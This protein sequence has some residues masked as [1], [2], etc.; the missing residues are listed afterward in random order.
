[1][2]LK[3]RW[4][5][6][7]LIVFL[8]SCSKD[9]ETIYYFYETVCPSCEA[10]QKMERISSRVLEY[11][12][13]ADKIEAKVY[14]IYE[15]EGAMDTFKQLLQER[16]IDGSALVPPILIIKDK[17]YAGFDEVENFLKR[18]ERRRNDD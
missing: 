2:M 3:K 11:G 8:F 14:D 9:V 13:N 6:A 15:T 16:N 12:R 18:E 10:S 17:L 4:V 5:V 7:V 1:M